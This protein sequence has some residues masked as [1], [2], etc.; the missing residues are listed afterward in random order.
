Y[1]DTARRSVPAGPRLLGHANGHERDVRGVRRP[2][3]TFG[4]RVT[5]VDEQV[6]QQLLQLTSVTAHGRQV[7]GHLEVEADARVETVQR[8]V[9]GTR[10]E[11][12]QV[13]RLPGR[14]FTSGELAQL[15]D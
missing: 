6:H 7:L 3:E 10:R 15:S 4:E 1:D 2:L 11:T 9:H 12:A 5:G 13:N 14:P 8:Q